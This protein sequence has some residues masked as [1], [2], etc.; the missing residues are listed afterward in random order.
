MGIGQGLRRTAK[1]GAFV[2]GLIL[3][4]SLPSIALAANT[5]VFSG[6]TP[7]VGSSTSPSKPMIS[8]IGYDKYGVKG[9]GKATMTLDGVGV[10][11]SFSWY[12]GWGYRKFKMTYQVTSALSLGSHKVVVRI[13]D[14]KGLKSRKTW[15][16]TVAVVDQMPPVTTSDVATIYSGPAT[17]HLVA[18]DNVGVTA[19]YYMLDGGAQTA[20]TV[21]TVSA[22][23]P[24]LLQFWSVDAAGNVEA[25]HM[26]FFTVSATVVPFVHATVTNSC[27]TAGS[28][29]HSGNIASIHAGM[30]DGGCANCHALSVAPMSDCTGNAACHATLPSFHSAATHIAIVSSTT[31]AAQTCTQ[32]I[33]HGNSGLPI[34]YN[35]KNGCAECHDSTR[36]GVPGAILAGGATCES[37]HDYATIHNAA[38]MATGHTVSGSCFAS[39]CHGTN[40]ATMH[41]I[42]FRGTGK[43]TIPGC[44]A[45]HAPG[46]T[47][48][49]DCQTCHSDITSPHNYVAAHAGA[50]ASYTVNVTAMLSTNSSA[51]V[52]CHGNDLTAVLPAGNPDTGVS[53]HKGCSCHAYAEAGQNNGLLPAGKVGCQN[54]HGTAQYSAHGFGAKNIASGHNTTTFGTIGG[55]SKFDGS[56]GVTLKDT[57]G[58]SVVTTWGLPTVNVFNPNA[59]DSSG[60]AMGWTSVITCQDCHTGLNLAGPHGASDN[61][62][63][64]PNYPYPYDMAVNSHYSQ[65]GMAARVDTTTFSSTA[66]SVNPRTPAFTGSLSTTAIPAAYAAAGLADASGLNNGVANNKYAVICAKCHKLFDFDNAY[67]VGNYSAGAHGFAFVN[68]TGIGNDSNTAHSSHHWDLNNGAAD[69]VSCHIAVPHGWT[70]P[71]LLVNS[72][73]G[74]YT[75]VSNGTTTT[76]TSVKDPAPYLDPLA[77]LMKPTSGSNLSARGMGPLSAADQHTLIGGGAFWTEANCIGCAGSGPSGL[78]HSGEDGAAKLK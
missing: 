9:V 20:G 50:T 54:C 71:R 45:C 72:Y 70:R 44:F 52:A 35:H 69:C 60:Q 59:K 12:S 25:L 2:A 16:F 5:T 3:A 26:V 8:V 40:V 66:L 36:A 4:L 39:T 62:G 24:H 11:R 13:T 76:A 46:K 77:R 29:C 57:T 63:I 14:R 22:A 32:A 55:K 6:L 38:N 37:C 27:T 19:T 51:C 68:A 43:A 34:A 56:Q 49:T 1:V 28:G 33:C 53:E 23:G 30:P 67:T 65:S 42:D 47:P 48:S 73:D 41:T 21:I 18:S 78:E 64:D 31:V 10:A 58:N 75:V 74:T 7:A 17:I 61:F 15:D